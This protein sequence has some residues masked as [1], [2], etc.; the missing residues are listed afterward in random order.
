MS[1]WRCD[2]S[3]TLLTRLA[4]CIHVQCEN[5][6]KVGAFKYRGALNAVKRYQESHPNEKTIFV[7]HSSGNHAQV[8][9]LGSVALLLSIIKAS[10]LFKCR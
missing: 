8:L 10:N 1:G 7:T 2:V 9:Y 4:D 3:S 6:Q 5:F